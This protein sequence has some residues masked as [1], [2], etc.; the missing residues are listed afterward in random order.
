MFMSMKIEEEVLVQ[1]VECVITRTSN[2]S[3][4]IQNGDQP[5]S[6]TEGVVT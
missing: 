4:S 5:I 6:F 2:D 1:N 3:D